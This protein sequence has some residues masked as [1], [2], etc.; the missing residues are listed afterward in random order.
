MKPGADLRRSGK[1]RFYPER[2]FLVRRESLFLF[3]N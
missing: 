2:R 3:D 1:R